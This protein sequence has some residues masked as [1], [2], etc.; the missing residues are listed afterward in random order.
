VRSAA[1]D[2]AV[3]PERIGGDLATSGGILLAEPV[4]YVTGF[5]IRP[6]TRSKTQKT[7]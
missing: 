1:F 4:Y 3:A 5:V 2:T 7:Q 6:A